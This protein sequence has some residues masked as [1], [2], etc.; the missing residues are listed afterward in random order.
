[1]NIEFINSFLF[2]QDQLKNKEKRDEVFNWSDGELTRHFWGWVNDS[3]DGVDSRLTAEPYVRYRDN[4]VVG[5]FYDGFYCAYM[6]HKN[7]YRWRAISCDE[8]H[9]GSLELT[10]HGSNKPFLAIYQ[11]K[12]GKNIGSF[13]KVIILRR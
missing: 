13:K 3:D 7:D 1:M 9:S 5:S 11:Y 6:D 12:K 4:E 10:D 8:R 2:N